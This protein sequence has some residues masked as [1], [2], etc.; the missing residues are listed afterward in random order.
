[1]KTGERIVVRVVMAPCRHIVNIEAP[2]PQL[3]DELYCRQCQAYRSVGEAPPNY[4][5]KCLTGK[6]G[7][8]RNAGADKEH[9]LALARKHLETRSKHKV[10]LLNGAHK[11]QELT[12]TDSVLFVTPSERAELAASNQNLMK[13]FLENSGQ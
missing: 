10:S 1:M 4:R 2:A 11:I 6:C 13:K 9:A 12:N 7:F 8:S 3:G 5:V